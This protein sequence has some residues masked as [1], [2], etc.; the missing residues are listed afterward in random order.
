MSKNS[1]FIY[2]FLKEENGKTITLIQLYSQIPIKQTYKPIMDKLKLSKPSTFSLYFQNKLL[3]D[4]ITLKEAGVPNYG[5]LFLKLQ[6]ESTLTT[7]KASVV[8]NS[9]KKPVSLQNQ[10]INQATQIMQPNWAT[11][12]LYEVVANKNVMPDSVNALID[13]SISLGSPLGWSPKKMSVRKIPVLSKLN[14]NSEKVAPKTNENTKLAEKAL[15][16]EKTLIKKIVLIQTFMRGKK[17]KKLFLLRKKKLR[18]R[19]CIIEEL[20]QSEGK[21]KNSLFCIKNNVILKFREKKFMTKEVEYTVFSTLEN[22]CELSENLHTILNGI[23]EGGFIKHRTKIAEVILKMMPYFKLYTPYF[24]NF[25]QSRV[26]LEKLRKSNGKLAIWLKENEH[27]PQLEN[28]DLSS[29]LIKPIQ[30]LPKYVLLFKDLKKNTEEAHPDYRNIVETLEK[31]EQIN[32]ELNSQMKEYLRK[33]RIFELQQIFG[34]PNKLQILEAGREFLEE[35][36]ISI[37][38]GDLPREAILYF[39]TDMLVVGCR[40]N[41]NDWKLLKSIVLDENSYCR[42]Q[43]DTQYFENV[44]TVYGKEAMTLCTDN[45]EN[46]LKAMGIVN[47]LIKGIK[48]KSRN[49]GVKTLNKGK[50]LA[51]MKQLQDHPVVI[52]VLGS[53]KRG[54]KNFNPYTVYVIQITKENWR[55]NLYFRYSELLKMD[56]M[57]KKEFLSIKMSHFPPKNWLNGNTP[58]VIESRKLLIEAFL[59]TLLQ[60][61]KI[62]ENSKKVMNFLGLPLNFYEIE[63][64]LNV[65]I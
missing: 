33:I 22:I 17:A 11:L 46:R 14:R 55:Q 63:A 3:I 35:E 19:N 18:Y 44:F 61:E 20:I 4:P 64:N 53:I 26:C 7:D 60:N 5:D 65:N 30:R 9:P 49:K 48:E 15:L 51:I 32:N 13:E 58:Q 29:L 43:Q 34:D 23:F 40:V 24:N 28:L 8:Q 56:E 52:K 36:A 1:P 54:V 37:I 50:T 38:L 25:D 27:M 16:A 41:N 6:Q 39:F 31:F 21:Y 45:L 2:V 57:V 59:Q 62:I 47:I 10:G 42:E 12:G